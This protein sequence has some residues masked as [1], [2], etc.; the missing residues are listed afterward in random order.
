MDNACVAWLNMLAGFDIESDFEDNT[1]PTSSKLDEWHYG[2]L[3]K[4]ASSLQDFQKSISDEK[5]ELDEAATRILSKENPKRKKKKIPEQGPPKALTESE[6]AWSE[7]SYK[8]KP[9]DINDMFRNELA[10]IPPTIP[11]DYDKCDYPLKPATPPHFRPMKCEIPLETILVSAMIP[12]HNSTKI[13]I[14]SLDGPECDSTEEECMNFAAMSFNDRLVLELASLGIQMPTPD[15]TGFEQAHVMRQLDSMARKGSDAIREANRA[16]ISLQSQ[17]LAK[18]D[19]IKK[20][21][22]VSKMFC[23]VDFETGSSGFGFNL[24]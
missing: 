23:D 12:H 3:E 1:K 2:M 22:E 6:R 7:V 15:V 5:K 17:L 14:S 24:P 18:I 16:R 21:N 11:P 10:L 9:I 20:H 8:W 4:L 19:D 13:D